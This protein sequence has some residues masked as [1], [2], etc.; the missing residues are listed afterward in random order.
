MSYD[1]CAV[2]CSFLKTHV[3]V[4]VFSMEWA[5]CSADAGHQAGKGHFDLD[6]WLALVPSHVLGGLRP[7]TH[8][9]S[10]QQSVGNYT[11]A[12]ETL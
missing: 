8:M 11:R 3:L 4:P 7:S 10:Y 12:V 5:H 1:I 9:L 6:M 2:S